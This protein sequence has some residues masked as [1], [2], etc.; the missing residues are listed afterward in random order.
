[1][2]LPRAA[3]RGQTCSEGRRH[4]KEGVAR[5]L[6]A[7]PRG[8]LPA[9]VPAPA[10]APQAAVAS[11]AGPPRGRV[12]GRGEEHQRG[13][14]REAEGVRGH[15]RQP[16]PAL[17][18]GLRLHAPHAAGRD[19]PALPLRAG[20]GRAGGRRAAHRGPR[21]AQGLRRRPEAQD[22]QGRD[23]RRGLPAGAGPAGVRVQRVHRTRPE[24][25][26]GVAPPVLPGR[27]G[28]T[29]AGDRLRVRRAVL[30]QNTG[31]QF[32]R[33]AKADA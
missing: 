21:L 6:P 3:W 30:R 7:A 32:C 8:P 26:P 5:V 33:I 13:G 1:M 29:G 31:G 25:P 22:I 19:A 12:E 10:G 17:A 16:R 27:P 20:R 11:A 4:Q 23:G 14:A 28:R 18:P 15:C 24:G 2:P 9:A